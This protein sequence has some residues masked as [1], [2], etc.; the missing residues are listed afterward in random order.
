MDISN[1]R[2]FA[3]ILLVFFIIFLIMII[4]TS[5]PPDYGIISADK[6]NIKPE[7][8]I[9][10]SEKQIEQFLHLILAINSSGDL[11]QVPIEEST[12]LSNLF[13]DTWSNIEYQDEYYYIRIYGIV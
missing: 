4:S 2:L 11:V 9:V 7:S 12:R 1:E 6:L 5:L 8:F 10:I 13:G 3:Y